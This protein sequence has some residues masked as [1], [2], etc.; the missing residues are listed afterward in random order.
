M[1]VA[2]KLWQ[3]T[4]FSNPLA[5]ALACTS[6][7]GY[8]D[9]DAWVRLFFVFGKRLFVRNKRREKGRGWTKAG[10]CNPPVNGFPGPRV[11]RHLMNLASFF[12]EAKPAST[13]PLEV[14]FDVER[15]NGRNPGP[16]L[17]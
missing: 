13:V 8:R 5:L 11:Y 17:G 1:P 14:V 10:R 6:Q 9:P 3:H 2:R 12:L 4:F 16:A 7:R 15:R